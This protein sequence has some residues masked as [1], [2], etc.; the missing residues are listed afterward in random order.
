MDPG[1]SPGIIEAG[2][3]GR[4]CLLFS[5]WYDSKCPLLTHAPISTAKPGDAQQWGSLK[6]A[7]KKCQILREWLAARHSLL[8]HTVSPSARE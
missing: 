3:E 2:G 7:Q 1:N 8:P 5:P 6:A 4:I